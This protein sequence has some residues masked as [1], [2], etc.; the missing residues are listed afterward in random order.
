M[1]AMAGSGDPVGVL[2]LQRLDHRLP[3][4]RLLGGEHP[5]DPGEAGLVRQEVADSDV[6]L[7]V[8]AELGPVAHDRRVN[9]KPVLLG[10]LVGADRGRPLGGRE[11]EDDRVLVPGP[12]GS[13]LGHSAPQVD[14]ELTAVVGGEGG[15]DLPPAGEAG[16]EDVAYLL[17]ARCGPTR[18]GAHPM[19]LS[20]LPSTPQHRRTF[21]HGVPGARQR[22]HVPRQVQPRRHDDAV[23]AA[24]AG[25]SAPAEE[26]DAN[27]W[28]PS[29]TQ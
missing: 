21:Y 9:V 4:Q 14:D 18:G 12:A 19:L 1:V 8:L 17:E 5:V 27:H 25:G 24:P 20:S 11:D 10:Q 3:R 28:P 7:A 23:R 22:W 29:S 15:A 6:R 16:L 2:V 26:A 13:L